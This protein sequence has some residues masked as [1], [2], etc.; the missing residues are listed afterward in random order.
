MRTPA[1]RTREDAFQLCGRATTALGLGHITTA[2]R[3][4]ASLREL[5][6]AHEEAGA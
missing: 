1:P 6:K 3:G 2:E 5:R 4:A